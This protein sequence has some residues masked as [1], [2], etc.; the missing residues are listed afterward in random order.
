MKII[1]SEDQEM[2]SPNGIVKALGVAWS[3]HTDE[4]TFEIP[5]SIETKPQT[6]RHLASEIA[7]MFDPMGWL[8]PVVLNAK[9][10][11][12]MLWNEKIGWDAQ[13]PEKYINSWMKIKSELNFIEKIRIPRWINFN[14][15]NK[16]QLHGFCDASE[17][18][19]AAAIYIK[20]VT[21]KTVRLLLSKSRVAPIKNDKN[22]SNV[23]IPPTS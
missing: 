18:G 13:V 15:G 4:F 17:N 7:S 21:E 11:L 2:H 6:K 19:Y 16:L 23:T 10:I 12:Q 5:I 22:N 1:P 9:H 3:P 14:P 8:S 20:N